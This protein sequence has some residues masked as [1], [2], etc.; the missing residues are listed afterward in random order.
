LDIG[1]K[2][3]D[4][5]KAALKDCKTVIWWALGSVRVKHLGDNSPVVTLVES[6]CL[7]G[8]FHALALHLDEGCT[9][10]AA[11]ERSDGRL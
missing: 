10:C 2:S 5:F 8:S 4:E 11:Q 6:K 7:A 3:I 9:M 1:P